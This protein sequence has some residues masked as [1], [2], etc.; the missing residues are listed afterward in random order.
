MDLSQIHKRSAYCKGK[1]KEQEIL[2][3]N[4][5]TEETLENLDILTGYSVEPLSPKD[6]NNSNSWSDLIDSV[7]SNEIPSGLF[8]QIFTFLGE[9]PDL[10]PPVPIRIDLIL[11]CS[12]NLT[13]LNRLE[14]EVSQGRRKRER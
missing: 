6:S 14:K 12:E 5:S 8:T 13:Y 2:T 4:K 9:D 10:P 7:E 1:K 3:K 11:T